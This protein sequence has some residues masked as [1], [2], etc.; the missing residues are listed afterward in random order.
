M[1]SRLV[2]ASFGVLLTL[3]F[4]GAVPAQEKDKEKPAAG[5]AGGDTETPSPSGSTYDRTSGK[6]EKATFAAGCFWSVEAVFER[7]PGVKSAVSGFSGGA[8]QFPSYAMVST[9]ETGHAESVQVEYDPKVISY[10]KLLAVFWK[11]HDPTTP[12]QQGDDFGPQYRSVIFFHTEAQRK[13]A[14][15]SYQELVK[16]RAFRAPIVTDLQPF[17]AFY[18]AEP[19]HQD[20]YVHHRGNYY[21]TAYIEP[22]LRKL[23][24]TGRAPKAAKKVTKPASKTAKGATA[25]R[26]QPP[27][28]GAEGAN[29]DQPGPK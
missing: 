22:K 8:V 23:H 4:V 21:C 10:E 14:L 29:G 13:A 5:K 27:A 12:N 20:Y 6:T 25:G 17:R 24:L 3:G 9:G 19:Y 1:T 26:G 11:V 15:E 28:D 16:R 18:P 7:V 2:A